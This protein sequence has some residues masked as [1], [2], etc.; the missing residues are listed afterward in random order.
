MRSIQQCHTKRRSLAHS[1]RSS[2]TTAGERSF[3]GRAALQV[4]RRRRALLRKLLLALLDLPTRDVGVA[5]LQLFDAP[6]PE[7]VMGRFLRSRTRLLSTSICPS[8]LVLVL[9]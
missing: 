5:P 1:A 9:T 6:L 3:Q 4:Q 8:W 2:L 7:W